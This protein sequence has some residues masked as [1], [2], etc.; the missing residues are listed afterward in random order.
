MRNAGYMSV[1]TKTKRTRALSPY[2][3]VNDAAGAI[4]FYKQVF[5]AHEE[6]RLTDPEGKI[7]HAELTIGG[8][9]MMLADEYVDFGALSPASVGGTPVHIHAYVEDLDAVVARALAAGAL[10]IRELKLEFFGDRT[11]TLV[12]PFGHHWQLASRV[13]DVSPAEVQRRWTALFAA[14]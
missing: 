14:N 8:A 6:F 1:E 13:E 2:L 10:L 12:D 3:I 9:C 4:E 5:G 11:C 7:G